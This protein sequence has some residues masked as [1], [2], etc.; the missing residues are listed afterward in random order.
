MLFDT[1]IAI[2]LLYDSLSSLFFSFSSFFMSVLFSLLQVVVA[3]QYFWQI[4]LPLLTN[5]RLQKASTSYDTHLHL[6]QQ[7]RS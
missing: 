6:S 5:N 4:C 7:F 3:M 1:K 2:K